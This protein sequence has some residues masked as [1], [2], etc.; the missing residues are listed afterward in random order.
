MTDAPTEALARA[1]GVAVRWSDVFGRSHDVS[2]ETLRSVLGALEI[3][4]ETDKQAAESLDRLRAPASAPPPLV[5]A[6]AG[7]AVA[8][9]FQARDYHYTLEDGRIFEGQTQLVAGRCVLPA[10]IEPGYHRVTLDDKLLTVAVAPARCYT[11]QDAEPGRSL[12]GLAVQ[13]YALRRAG[14]GGIG[15]FGGLAQFAGAA[16]RHGASA[17]AISPVHAQFTA[18][19]GRFSPY[20]PS[21]RTMLNVLHAPL[22]AAPSSSAHASLT[23]FEALDLV[24]WPGAS[25]ARLVVLREWFAKAEQD[26]DSIEA[27][28]AFRAA[29]GEALES[30]ATFEALHAHFLGLVQPIWNWREWPAEFRD[31]DAQAVKTFATQNAETVR[32]HAF[33]QYVADAGLGRAQAAAHAAGMPIGL[34]SD[35]AVGTAAGGSHCWSRQ[36]EMLLGLSVGAPPDLLSRDGQDWGLAAFSP[37]GLAQHG[38]RAF[39]EMLQASLRHAGGV[40][41]DHG[42]GLNRLWVVPEGSRSSEGAYLAFPEQDLLRLVRLESQRHQAIVLAEDL[43][44]VPEGFQQRLQ[45]AGVFG[46]R[47]L[48]FERTEESFSAPAAWEPQAAAMTSTHDLPTVAGWWAGRDLDWR[49]QLGLFGPDGIEPER[50]ARIA[51]RDRLWAAFRQS[52]AA[53]DGPPGAADREAVADAAVLHTALSASELFMLPL[54]DALAATEQPNLP[55]TLDQ[56]PNWRRRFAGAADQLLEAP[57][58]AARLAKLNQARRA[59]EKIR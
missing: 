13:L 33:L 38:F 10:I 18:D 9:P 44:T 49:E 51:D 25:R 32:F 58:V 5:T 48:A 16:A 14:D 12:W 39:I 53:T 34:I 23:G 1:A 30:H 47:V 22:D 56:H 40:R 59:P 19:P 57:A 37:F 21:S 31:P 36:S 6:E 7:H 26:S 35:L 46:M 3:P 2:A 15:D 54:E 24:D 11:V 29:G 50:E 20:A 17:I 28:R 8:V 45:S 43:G 27:L 55:G 41:I 52:G 42:M 4:A